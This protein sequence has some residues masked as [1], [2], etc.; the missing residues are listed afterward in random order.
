[1]RTVKQSVQIR[2]AALLLA[3]MLLPACL[4][5]TAAAEEGL[6]DVT[7]MLAQSAV[8]SYGLK[9]AEGKALVPRSAPEILG[10]GLPDETGVEPDY[11]GIVGYASL[12]TAWDV[13]RFNTF[14]KTPWLLPVYDRNGD[15]WTERSDRVIRHKTPVLVVDQ[16]IREGLGHKF[17]GYLSVIRLDSLEPAWIDVT[18]FCT[19][20]YWTLELSDAVQYGYCIA[21]YRNHSRYE[22]LDRK[23]HRGALPDGTRILM[24]DKRTS[25]YFSSDR[26]LNPLLGIVFRSPLEGDSFYRTFLFFNPDDLT[27]L[28]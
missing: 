22:P 17:M 11:R 15:S 6:E 19:V 24:C 7:M 9:D 21:V 8:D 18:Q 20:P 5:R 13:S 1:V 25:R 26:D 14:G 10:R 2:A 16:V 3:L 23:N 12:Q 28:Y 27:L 4:A